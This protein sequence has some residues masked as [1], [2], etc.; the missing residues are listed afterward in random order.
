MKKLLFFFLIA[1]SLLFGQQII[2]NVEKVNSCSYTD[3][4]VITKPLEDDFRLINLENNTIS[5]GGDI[6]PI[7]SAE[8]SG[9]FY[10][11]KFGGAAFLKMAIQNEDVM[12][13]ISA[14]DYIEQRDA[15]LGTIITW[16][17]CKII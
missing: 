11:F 7:T 2:C 5:V 13:N 14:G 10:F 15:L 12:F 6:S 17:T 8:Q 9:I 16:G 4:C 3:G 1:P